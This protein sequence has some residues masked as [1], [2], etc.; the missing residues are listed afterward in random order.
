MHFAGDGFLPAHLVVNP[1]NLPYDVGALQVV[2]P[3]DIFLQPVA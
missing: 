2:A 3:E 1:W